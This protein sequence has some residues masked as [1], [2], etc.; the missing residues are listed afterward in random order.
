MIK[1]ALQSSLTNDVK[2]RSMGVGAMPSAEYLI[3]S[4]ILTQTSTLIEFNNLAEHHGT[5]R[6]LKLVVCTRNIQNTGTGSLITRFNGDGALNYAYHE[7][8]G[9]G[10][11]VTPSAIAP[12]NSIYTSWNP[13][14]NSNPG[15]WGVAEV[16]ILDWASS[17]K[18][19]TVRSLTGV[20]SFANFITM[21]SG[22]WRS[23]SPITSI[24]LIA[25]GGN[26]YAIGSR[27][28]LYGVN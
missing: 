17:T 9:N 10:S 22:H 26:P 21:M 18:F 5:Y 24:Q 19:K 16:D 13:H 27:Y 11:T 15:N 14:G 6:H 12:L 28:S 25:E 4:A 2:Y 1:S 23:T 20:L 7:I 8:R 3:Q